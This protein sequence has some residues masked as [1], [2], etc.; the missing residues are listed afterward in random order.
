MEM[1][2]MNLYIIH[3]VLYDYT[4][5]MVVI[6]A[7]DLDRCREIFAEEFCNDWA[8]R[9]NQYDEAIKYGAYKVLQ[10]V[11]QSEGVV[12]YVYGGA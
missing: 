4:A 2:K 10:V 5:G 11:G 9:M 7:A 8:D 3:E 1:K 12:S 6:A